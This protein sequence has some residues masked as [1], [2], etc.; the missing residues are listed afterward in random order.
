[1]YRPGAQIFRGRWIRSVAE[2]ALMSL[3]PGAR[4][5]RYEIVAPLGSGGM[6]GKEKGRRLPAGLT[7]NYRLS[8]YTT[9][10]CSTV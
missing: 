1:M 3:A 10:L 2:S 7:T 9:G 5:G 6:G 4:L 8:D